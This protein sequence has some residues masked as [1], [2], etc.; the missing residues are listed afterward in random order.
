MGKSNGRSVGARGRVR[1]DGKFLALDGE[2]FTVRGVTYGTFAPRADGALYPDTEQI[3]ADLEAMRSAGFNTLR[4]YT[5][6]PPDLLSIAAE[7][8]LH[9]IAG[10][11]YPDWRYLVGDGRRRRAR[12]ASEAAAQVRADMKRLAGHAEVLAVCIGNEVPADAIRW[13]GKGAVASVLEGLA[14][15]AHGIDPGMLVTYG[16]YPTGEYL[17]LERTDVVMFNVFLERSEDF[18]RYLNRLHNL[19]GDRPLLLGELGLH[20]GASAADEEAQAVLIEEQVKVALERGAAGTCLFSWTDDWHVGGNRVEGWRFG[21]TRADR[22]PRSALARAA[23]A[24]AMTVR[25]LDWAW[26]SMSVVICAWNSAATIDECLQHVCALDYPN[27]EVIVVDDGSTDATAEIAR[28]HRRVRVLSVPH[29]GLSVARNAGLAAARGDVVAYLDADAYPSPEWPYYL[30]LGMDRANVAAVGGPNLPPPSD[31]LKAQAVARAP[32]GPSHVLLTDDRAEHI[33][34][35]NMAFWRQMVIEIGGFDPIYTAAGDDVDLCWRLLDRGYAI[36]FHPAA[37]VWHHRRGGRR[38]YLR[39]QQGY[40]RAETLVAAR[41]PDRFTSLGGARWRGALYNGF[42]P[43]LARQPVYRGRFG[44]AAFQSIYRGQDHSFDLAHQAGI[45]L[46]VALVPFLLSNVPGIRGAGLVAL[47]L[48]AGLFAV[49]A[50]RIRPPRT[51][52]R[53]SLGFR[54]E[55]ATL[56]V[57]QPVA[58]LLGR[59]AYF[60]DAS[61]GVQAAPWSSAGWATRKRNMVM[62]ATQTPRV[63]LAAELVR[64]FRRRSFAVITSTGWEEHDCRVLAS[65]LVAGDVTSTAHVPGVVQFRARSR[66]RAAPLAGFLVLAA[67]A[68]TATPIAALIVLLAVGVELARGLWCTWFVIPSLV[69]EAI[70]VTRQGAAHPAE[71]AITSTPRIGETANS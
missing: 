32:G 22:T 25:D 70:G 29:A 71:G 26:P 47:G 19:A 52:P 45:P 23:K 58:R 13:V 17:T 14:D 33:P 40:G 37:T 63:D 39:Q 38:A 5:A 36:A 27:L 62:V 11:F 57:L 59:L 51:M 41:H 54:L 61:R 15:L 42:P 68:A 60:D 46:A 65:T 34:G 50:A 49:D 67:L 21:L 53:L 43:L 48:I 28:R 1:V 2:R 8:D 3:R 66:L 16:G 69:V 12:I 56:F 24:Q 64:H 18:R 10:I 6:P 44:T 20:A 9:V 35:C 4:T 30:A 7:Q 55:V 31:P